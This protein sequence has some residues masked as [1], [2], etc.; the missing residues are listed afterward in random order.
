MDPQRNGHA[1]GRDISSILEDW[2]FLVAQDAATLAQSVEH[3]LTVDL[4]GRKGIAAGLKGKKVILVF[5]NFGEERK[6]E[7]DALEMVRAA[8]PAALRVWKPF[9][10]GDE[11]TPDLKA[12]AAR[13]S[14]AELLY[15]DKP[16][17]Y[18]PPPARPERRADWPCTDMGN[19][20]RMAARY[21]PVLRYL[22]PWKKWLWWNG[23]RWA[24]DEIGKVDMFAKAT[25]RAIYEEAGG[26]FDDDQRK[27]FARWAIASE[28]ANRIDAMLR[29]VRAEPRIPIIPGALD[30]NPWLFN[31]PNGT[32]D[33]KTGQLKDHERADLIT[34]MSPIEFEPAAECPLWEQ[35]IGRIFAGDETLIGFVQRLFGIALTGDCS[36]QI[37]PIFF[38]EGGN[39]K[40]TILG[41]ILEMM[42][43][44]YAIV[45][46]P[47]LL[48]G[49][50]NGKHPTDKA[51]LFGMRL[52]VDF[53]SA[54]SAHL[55]EAVVKQLT[56]SDRISA[57]RM[58]EDFWTFLP[59]HKLIL[60]T[61]NQPQVAEAKNAI[62]R[63]LKLVP[64]TVEIPEA[65][66]QTDLPKRLALELP[67]ILAWCVRGCVDW[68]Q[69]GLKTPD[70]VKE[71]TAEYR[72]EEDSL[73]NFIIEECLTGPTYRV[74][75]SKLYEHFRTC[76]DR[77]GQVTMTIT[78]F[79]RAMRKR[80]FERDRSNGT[81]YCGIALRHSDESNGYAH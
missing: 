78:A 45:A 28:S 20:E 75:S 76:L 54:E 14:I 64:F 18:E 41:I 65:E 79:G 66:Q 25:V 31:C 67:G 35:T 47:G 53:E 80:G 55:N 17:Q 34:R 40:S 27:Q 32:I 3:G 29:L 22:K 6:E 74:K 48:F 50:G 57:R 5:Q 81:W 30:F 37:L 10:L 21:G 61:N 8:E 51:S 1:R 49:S 15:Y 33:L 62:W 36:E 43:P 77:F 56:G 26:A 9:G 19:G 39:G 70:T 73:G 46:P 60:C 23:Q 42:G 44:D 69:Y 13:Y 24:P 72:A 58:R 7:Y 63:R 12:L 4:W 52:V 38:G 11:A 71:A 68:V 16:W 59:T 2:I